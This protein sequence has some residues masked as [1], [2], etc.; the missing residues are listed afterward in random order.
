MPPIP[1]GSSYAVPLLSTGTNLA[2]I[3]LISLHLAYALPFFALL[4]AGPNPGSG[5]L[6]LL[7]S[8]FMSA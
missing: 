2:P 6:T 4:P 1:Q 3:I 5:L 7:T 8:L